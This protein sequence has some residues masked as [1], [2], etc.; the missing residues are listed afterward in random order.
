MKKVVK[1][2]LCDT[3]TANRLGEYQHLSRR[4]F[5]YFREELYRTKS[6]KFFLHG[7]GG[8]ASKYSKK[9]AQNEWSGGETIQLLP[10][11]AARQWAEEHLDGDEYISAFGEPEDDDAQ[12]TVS[13]DAVTKNR[14][15]KLKMMTGKTLK[16][17]I[18]IAVLKL[19]TS[20]SDKIDKNEAGE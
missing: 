10:P 20:E 14:L 5:N 11:E 2:V 19:E 1:G 9:I 12:Y 3:E 16:Q 7:E 4:D 6:G 15:D 17:L 13:I 18:A 8:P